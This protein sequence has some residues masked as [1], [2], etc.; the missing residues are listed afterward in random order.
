[1]AREVTVVDSQ[2]QRVGG[3]V[4]E[5]TE[6]HARAVDGARGEHG[7]QCAVDPPHI[8][9]ETAL[10]HIPGRAGRLRREQNQVGGV[11]LI[12]EE[13]EAR[14]GRRARAMEEDHQGTWAPLPR[15]WRDREK[16]P[17]RKLEH[18]ARGGGRGVV[19]RA[20][21]QPARGGGRV[22]HCVLLPGIACLDSSTGSV[23]IWY[24]MSTEVV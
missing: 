16:R 13:R 14:G 18:S 3:A 19:A 15:R 9:A 4:R 20:S 10:D 17:I 22:L 2:R 7:G 1:M 21:C 24:R 5:A 8:R 6:D 23:L 12:R 11:C